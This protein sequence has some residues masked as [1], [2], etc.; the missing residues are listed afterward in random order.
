MT[1]KY[2]EDALTLAKSRADS[3]HEKT[4]VLKGETMFNILQRHFNFLWMVKALFT[5]RLT[6]NQAVAFRLEY[7]SYRNAP[8][9]QSELWKKCKIFSIDTTKK[10]PTDKSKVAVDSA[11]TSGPVVPLD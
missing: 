11:A 2:Y 3:R 9:I 1:W 6:H 5:E 4:Q 10:I 8:T 7:L